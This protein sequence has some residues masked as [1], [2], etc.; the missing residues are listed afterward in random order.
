MKKYLGVK[1]VQAELQI[2]PSYIK[3][4]ADESQ[5]VPEQEGYKVVYEDGYTSWSPKEVFEK[6]YRILDVE[7]AANLAV[8]LN[9]GNWQFLH[10]EESGDRDSVQ[11]SEIP[12]REQNE[13]EDHIINGPLTVRELYEFA[14]EHGRL[15][16]KILFTGKEEGKSMK[17]IYTSNVTHFGEGWSKDTV[18]IH[19]TYK[20][21]TNEGGVQG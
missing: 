1:V 6:A 17:D 12:V 14:K 7:D 10:N 13:L 16:A 2:Q 3:E 18:M 9:S 4:G 5:R 20:K 19:T 21:D 11:N 15:D 8:D